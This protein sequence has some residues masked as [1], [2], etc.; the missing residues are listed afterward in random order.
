M[1]YEGTPLYN[2]SVPNLL[3]IPGKTA[4]WVAPENAK[5]ATGTEQITWDEAMVANVCPEGWHVPTKDEL[6]AMTGLPADEAFYSENYDAIKAAFPAANDYWSSTEYELDAAS[7]AWYLSVTNNSARVAW[8][9]RLVE[10]RMRC[11]RAK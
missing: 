1:A 6:V 5:N 10:A 3:A 4:Y 9:F 11:V 2:S 7:K 8:T